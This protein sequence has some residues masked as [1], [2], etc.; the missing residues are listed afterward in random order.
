MSGFR[1]PRIWPLNP[2][3]MDNKIKPLEVDTII[4][5]N[6]AWSEKYYTTK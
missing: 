3:A 1:T 6:N 4:N 2:R 5:L